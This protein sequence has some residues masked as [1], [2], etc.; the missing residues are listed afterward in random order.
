MIFCVVLRKWSTARSSSGIAR[1][2]TTP[3]SGLTTTRRPS[4]VPT[5]ERSAAAS[6]GHRF[7]SER[8]STR[9]PDTVRVPTLVPS[10]P[11]ALPPAPLRFRTTSLSWPALTRILDSPLRAIFR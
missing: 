5:I 6:S 7:D 8:V 10:A 11:V 9:L 4:P 2:S 1:T 3:A